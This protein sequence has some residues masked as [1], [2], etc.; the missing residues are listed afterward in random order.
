MTDHVERDD[1]DLDLPARLAE[2]LARLQRTPAVPPE[3]DAAILAS[4]RLRMRRQRRFRRIARWVGPAVAAA[5]VLAVVLYP[6]PVAHQ[7]EVM[8]AFR[9][10]ARPTILD[11]F[12][13]ARQ[14]K[15]HPVRDRR[16][17]INDDGVVDRRDVDAL[18]RAAVRLEGERA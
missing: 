12:S 11:A 6:S 13:L 2:D 15:E 14:L 17:D 9:A 1:R 5:A 8:R 16:F 10:A 4:G 7:P 3:V 18:A